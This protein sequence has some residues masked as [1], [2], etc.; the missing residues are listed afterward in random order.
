MF[1][2]V[3]LGNILSPMRDRQNYKQ[4]QHQ[5]YF[6]KHL[7]CYDSVLKERLIMPKGKRRKRLRIVGIGDWLNGSVGRG[8]AQD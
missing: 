2:F 7:K 6:N 3:R 1:S 8:I 4:L 5:F